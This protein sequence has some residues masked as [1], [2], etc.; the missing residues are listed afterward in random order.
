MAVVIA[1]GIW[2]VKF[3]CPTGSCNRE[4]LYFNWFLGRCLLF[5]H[6]T[7]AYTIIWIYRIH[8]W[9][10]KWQRDPVRSIFEPCNIHDKDQIFLG[11]ISA[12]GRRVVWAGV[13]TM[14][15]T[16]WV[17]CTGQPL[18]SKSK[19]YIRFSVLRVTEKKGA[20]K[21]ARISP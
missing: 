2:G 21:N 18:F 17:D 3:P 4:E 9:K 8:C 15:K 11:V 1:F 16:L 12:D 7:T 6:P 13:Q 10:K 5:G 14:P 20:S 19:Q